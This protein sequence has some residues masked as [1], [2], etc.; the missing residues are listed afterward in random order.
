MKDG[1]KGSV[2]NTSLS[3]PDT[4]VTPKETLNYRYDLT[5]ASTYPLPTNTSPL[6]HGIMRNDHSTSFSESGS[7]FRPSS[8][9]PR[10]LGFD[11]DPV[12]ESKKAE[13]FHYF[14]KNI[15]PA[16]DAYDPHKYFTEVV[17]SQATLSRPLLEFILAVSARHSHA[18]Q[19]GQRKSTK[20]DVNINRFVFTGLDGDARDVALLLHRFVLN[21]DGT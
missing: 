13:L 18:S 20:P 2:S 15:G 19:K 1:G 7:I 8:A 11:G 21:M 9:S 5:H 17:P 12:N 16:L 3:F 4:L 6:V 10:H 14:V